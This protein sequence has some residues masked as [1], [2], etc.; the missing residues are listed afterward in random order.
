MNGLQGLIDF[1]LRNP[2]QS[3]VFL[4]IAISI[5]RRLVRQAS[6]DQLRRNARGAQLPTRREDDLR[7]KVRRGFE[8]MMRQRAAATTTAGKGPPRVAPNVAP[9]P[10][11]APKPSRFAGAPP[12]IAPPPAI[13]VVAAQA[14]ATRTAALAKA[15]LAGRRAPPPIPSIARRLLNDRASVRRAF[16]LREILDEARSMRTGS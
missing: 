6:E 10:K 3:F 7:E 5:L 4:L 13:D 8:E 12:A 1:L 15:K 2:L 16:L 9:R 14:A 11:P